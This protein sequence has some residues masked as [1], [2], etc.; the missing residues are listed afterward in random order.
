MRHD[1][2]ADLRILDNG[3]GFSVEALHSGFGLKGLRERADAIAAS[4]SIESNEGKGTD[5]TAK[6]SRL[7]RESLRHNQSV[8][9]V[10]CLN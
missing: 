10:L 1:D 3:K 5:I 6:F 4:L 7:F 9:K 2:R 8:L